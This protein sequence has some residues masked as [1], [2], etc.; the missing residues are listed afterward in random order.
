MERRMNRWIAASAVALVIA[1]GCGDAADAG[2]PRGQFVSKCA[3]SHSLS[4]DPIMHPGDPGAS[5]RHDFFGSTETSADSTA[6]ELAHGDSTC[7]LA[8][9]TAAY[10]FPSGYAGDTLLA[11]TFAKAYYFGLPLRTVVVPPFGLQMVAGNAEAE[12]PSDNPQATWSCGAAGPRRTPIEDHPYDC[13]PFVERWPF[14]DSVVARLQFP[15]CWDGVGLEPEDVVYP[16]DRACPLGFRNRLPAFRTQIHFGILDPCEPGTD[17]RPSSTGEN[18]ILTL[19]SGPYFTLHADFWNT[20]RLKI[21]TAL[22]SRCL[23]GHIDC[24]T[25]TDT[26]EGRA[27]DSGGPTLRP[28][29]RRR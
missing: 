4:D 10:W 16:V 6:R 21:L 18:V 9:D 17:C 14:V 2:P 20:W 27:R 13:T 19:S 26:E 22:V 11:P 3:Y 12:S 7:L 5:H 24:G 29:P 15:N 28:V 23:D 8:A 1:L 25:V